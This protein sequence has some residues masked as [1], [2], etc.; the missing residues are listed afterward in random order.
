[1]TAAQQTCEE[2]R[3]MKVLESRDE[4]ETALHRHDRASKVDPGG[5][6]AALGPAHRP[7]CASRQHTIARNPTNMEMTILDLMSG[8]PL[9][10]RGPRLTRAGV[11]VDPV[12]LGLHCCRGD[13]RS[14]GRQAELI[15]VGQ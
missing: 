4:E 5:I 12:Q 6:T 15:E 7:N 8:F 2:D 1:M 3:D 10:P 11:Q 13:G 9:A 14:S